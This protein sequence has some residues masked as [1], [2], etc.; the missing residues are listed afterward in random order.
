MRRMPSGIMA[1]ALIAAAGLLSDMPPLALDRPGPRGKR[2]RPAAPEPRASDDD[3][4]QVK[5]ARARALAKRRD[6]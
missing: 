6:D 3:S 1:G 2:I 5:R 4:R